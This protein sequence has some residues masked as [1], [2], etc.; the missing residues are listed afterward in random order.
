MCPPNGGREI[1]IGAMRI[2]R[3]LFQRKFFDLGHH[4]V[5]FTALRTG[6]G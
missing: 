6:G 2:E 3:T 5:R 4:S 1:G